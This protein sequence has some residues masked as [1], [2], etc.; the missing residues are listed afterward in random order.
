MLVAVGLSGSAWGVDIMATGTYIDSV[1]GA[2]SSWT[3][4]LAAA[5]TRIEGSLVVTGGAP[6]GPVALEGE[7]VD[8]IVILRVSG[9][10]DSPII[11]VKIPERFQLAGPLS[12]ATV[13]AGGRQHRIS[14]T[15]ALAPGTPAREAPLQAPTVEAQMVDTT[16][17]RGDPRTHHDFC[18]FFDAGLTIPTMSGALELELA[19]ACAYR[20]MTMGM[21]ARG[22]LV[23]FFQR[24]LS[25]LSPSAL[26][27]AIVLVNDRT[28]D[29]DNFP[30][31][32][33]VEV[34]LAV[35]AADP[36]KAVTAFL[37]LGGEPDAFGF[38]GYS[39]NWA[40]SGDSGRSW[41]DDGE[42]RHYDTGIGPVDLPSLADP[43][44]AS[45]RAGTFYVAHL[46]SEEFD[47]RVSSNLGIAR[48]TDNGLTFTYPAPVE[49]SLQNLSDKP[50]MAID[51]NAPSASPYSGT[52]YVCFTEFSCPNPLQS[53]IRVARST[54][55]GT[56]YNPLGGAEV[57]GCGSQQACSV[58]VGSEG[59]VYVGWANY[60]L[61]AIVMRRSLD[62]GITWDPPPTSGATVIGP[63][64]AMPADPAC[65][66]PALNGHVRQRPFA[67]L[68][69][70][71][72]VSGEVYAAWDS[73]LLSG[74]MNI[75]FARSTDAGGTWQAPQVVN[76]V[77]SG[78]KFFARIGVAKVNG[79]N[80][81]Y[82]WIRVI[83][84]DR[85][86]DPANMNLDVF[87]DDSL[88]EGLG[89][90]A[91]DVRIDTGNPMP[92]PELVPPYDGR[93]LC[94]FGDYLGLAWG[95][96]NVG[97]IEAWADTRCTAC[98]DAPSPC[99]PDPVTGSNCF[100][101]PDI[102]VRAGC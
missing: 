28:S 84:Y 36:S 46:H 3:A 43:V 79:P 57:A 83:W 69:A 29:L 47:L 26:R 31:V 55:G 15:W 37:D 22:W 96:G 54:D 21:K 89:W 70:D 1:S 7:I 77:G 24:T 98:G 87:A 25:F 62:G 27:A 38:V 13:Q 91:S 102:R 78:D 63:A 23:A 35:S 65:G 75:L 11:R 68:A 85:R 101:D 16:R 42:L 95:G 2:E 71:P 76:T 52:V 53:R 93:S 10:E 9:S 82:S 80:G 20:R 92:L 41:V 49:N 40:H 59:N 88:E 34:S 33:Q 48:S 58:A 73:L 97:W 12:D 44:V 61:A 17:D 4:R 50:E 94:F 18:Q 90:G 5:G 74:G 19:R 6:F 14:G 8:D 30:R 39:V 32:T 51:V 99:P 64:V 56:T 67:N 81:P 72:V 100:P 45:D 66:R 86:R 60:D